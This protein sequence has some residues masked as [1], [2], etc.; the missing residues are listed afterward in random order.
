MAFKS[1]KKMSVF[2]SKKNGII[3]QNKDFIVKKS[4]LPEAGLGLFANRNFKKG[5]SL[6]SYK[7]KLLT[8]EECYMKKYLPHWSHMLDIEQLGKEKYVAVHPPKNMFLRYINHA[9]TQVNGKKVK[10]KKSIN[11]KF[12]E[13][14][15]P[16]YIE[17]VTIKDVQK[18]DEFYLYYGPGFSQS[19]LNNP[20]LKAFYLSED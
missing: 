10:G 6:G 2:M 3:L 1:L 7:G 20:K 14:P 15:D 5:E 4:L 11:V 17:I 13:I 19:Y 16:P 12:S 9:P 8:M 18:G